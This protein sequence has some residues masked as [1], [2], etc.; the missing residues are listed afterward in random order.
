MLTTFALFT[1]TRPRA[2]LYPGEQFE[3]EHY[4]TCFCVLLI[5]AQ[6]CAYPVPRHVSLSG[7]RSN[8][9]QSSLVATVYFS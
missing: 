3:E 5:N 4:L 6:L 7:V 1:V 9:T 8:P 2:I